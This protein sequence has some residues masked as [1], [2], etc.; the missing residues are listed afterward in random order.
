MTY[1]E[2]VQARV[3]KITEEIATAWLDHSMREGA[4]FTNPGTDDELKALRVELIEG[5]VSDINEIEAIDEELKLRADAAA[6]KKAAVEKAARERM[7]D[8]QDRI[9][10]TVLSTAGLAGTPSYLLRSYFHGGKPASSS[11]VFRDYLASL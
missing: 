10:R 1:V 6:E 2:E 3:G 8:W 11:N 9:N 5:V 4:D 7:E